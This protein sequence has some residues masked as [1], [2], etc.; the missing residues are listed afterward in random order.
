[1]ISSSVVGTEKSSEEKMR[2]RTTQRALLSGIALISSC[3]V[4]MA[5][6]PAGGG[7]APGGPPPPRPGLSVTSPA[8]PDGGEVPMKYSGRGDNKSPAFEFH[9]TLGPTATPAPDARNT[10]A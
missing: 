1:M 10:T 7:A 3:A 5:Q 8:W 6:A 9:V 4:V 2:M